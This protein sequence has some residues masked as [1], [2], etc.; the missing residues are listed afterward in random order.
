[1]IGFNGFFGLYWFIG[2]AGLPES[3]RSHKT[4]PSL[5]QHQRHHSNVSRTHRRS[6]TS[7]Q[8]DDPRRITKLTQVS[9][10]RVMR[11]SNAHPSYSW[12]TNRHELIEVEVE[13]I[14]S[15]CGRETGCLGGIVSRRGWETR[16][17]V[18][19]SAEGKTTGSGSYQEAVWEEYSL[20]PAHP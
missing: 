1:M 17:L 16:C 14:I 18:R 20:N 12:H 19:A 5:A 4:R 15:R 2:L 8:V 13:G 3:H 11:A 7:Q 9:H 6:A 10:E